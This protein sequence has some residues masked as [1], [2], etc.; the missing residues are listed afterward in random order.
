MIVR[1]DNNI[2]YHFWFFGR[3][4]GCRVWKYSL[5]LFLFINT[6]RRGKS[7]E[8]QTEKRAHEATGESK[9]KATDDE[10]KDKNKPSF[11]TLGIIPI[12]PTFE[13]TYDEEVC[14]SQWRDHFRQLCE[15]KVQF[16]HCRM[17]LKDSANPKA[18]L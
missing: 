15:Y 2:E 4:P 3:R 5:S 16:G 1:L 10:T 11:D 12:F 9:H 7:D 8:K 17:S 13:A 18:A 6:T 14:H